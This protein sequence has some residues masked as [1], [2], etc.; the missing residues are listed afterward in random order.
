MNEIFPQAYAIGI[1]WEQFWSFNPRIIKAYM[2]AYEQR[3]IQQ[4]YL[5]WINGQYTLS[6]VLYAVEHCLSGKKA[7]TEYIKR[8][9]LQEM[10]KNNITNEE[11]LQKQR[12][13]FLAKLQAM[14]AN[15]ELS[16][17]KK[18]AGE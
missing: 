11:E 4:D 10:Q 17:P 2:K 7:K 3:M 16:H 15:F 6:A 14:Q 1:S 13:L 12:N 18:K 8:P 9:V 5:N